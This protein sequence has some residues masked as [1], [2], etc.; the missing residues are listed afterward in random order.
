MDRNGGQWFVLHALSGH[1]NKVR[2]NI[3]T[4]LRQAETA[5]PV[6]E[7]LVPTEKITEFRQNKKTVV[8]VEAG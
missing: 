3:K 2:E 6:Y 1:E 7:V 4:A 5:L 8:S